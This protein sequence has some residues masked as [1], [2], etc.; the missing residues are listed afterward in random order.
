MTTFPSRFAAPAWRSASEAAVP[1]TDSTTTSAD[2]AASAK[3]PTPAFG[4]VARQAVN[5][6][7]WRVPIITS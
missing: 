6:S 7:T 3:L 2:A 5:F 1:F 4:F